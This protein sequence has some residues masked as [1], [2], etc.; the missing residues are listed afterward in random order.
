MLCEVVFITFLS[1]DAAR[2]RVHHVLS[3]DASESHAKI[4]LILRAF[5]NSCKNPLPCEATA[6]RTVVMH[7]L[8]EGC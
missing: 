2:R 7:A 6:K 3:S 5:C 1:S 4:L 8:G